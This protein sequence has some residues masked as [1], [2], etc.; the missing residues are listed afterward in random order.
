MFA[1]Y[2]YGLSTTYTELPQHLV[3]DGQG[4]YTISARTTTYLWRIYD[5]NKTFTLK[6]LTMDVTAVDSEGNPTADNMGI[7]FMYQTNNSVVT[8][9]HST[10]KSTNNIALHAQQRKGGAYVIQDSTIYGGTYG[11]YYNDSDHALNIT[12]STIHGGTYGILVTGGNPCTN[13][14]ITDS[15]VTAGI[16]L[17]SG[18]AKVTLAGKTVVDST[19]IATIYK[20]GNGNPIYAGSEYAVQITT[21]NNA[22]TVK[23]NAKIVGSVNHIAGGLTINE[24]T[25]I[26]RQRGNVYYFYDTVD[27]AFGEWAEGDT[28][29]TYSKA[30]A[31]AIDPTKYNVATDVNDAYQITKIA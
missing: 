7:V 30:V 22:L 16:Y 21:G 13:V 24:S 1:N 27:A 10:I 6:N 28:V 11:I 20:D 31:D 19:L 8:I 2:D 29:F 12:N 3:I 15:T 5:D 23:D 14:T 9:D 17:N 18:E 26:I 4:K 25:Q